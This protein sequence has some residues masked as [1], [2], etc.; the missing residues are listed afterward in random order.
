MAAGFVAGFVAGFFADP[1]GAAGG[2]AAAASRPCRPRASS[3]GVD[4]R[5][6]CSP[7]TRSTV[8]SWR[9]SL[10]IVAPGTCRRSSAA[11]RAPAGPYRTSAAPSTGRMP[12]SGSLSVA[13]IT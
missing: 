4:R 11:A 7:S 3:A 8:A 13:T 12:E 1:A 9:A 10:Y 2:V 5:R 6:N